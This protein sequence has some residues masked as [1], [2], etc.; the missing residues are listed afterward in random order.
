MKQ[1]LLLIILLGLLVNLKTKAQTAYYPNQVSIQYGVFSTAFLD[2]YYNSI[3]QSSSFNVSNR[4]G[5]V[6][7]SYN[8]SVT[9]RIR[10][11]ASF[12]Y[13]ER[14]FSYTDY[15]SSSQILQY[16]LNPKAFTFA[17]EFTFMYGINGFVRPY[18]KIA[19][20]V[21][22]REYDWGNSPYGYDYLTEK[23]TVFSLH[24][25]PIGFE[26]GNEICGFLS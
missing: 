4:I 7:V 11:G 15:W 2:L 8:H 1:K 3:F 5:P 10:L 6:G 12:I 19:P 24:L 16:S 20:G 23:E 13:E 14:K 21:S 17:G 18:G 9:P 25:T 26:F 22:L